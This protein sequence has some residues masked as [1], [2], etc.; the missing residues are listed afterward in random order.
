MLRMHAT[1]FMQ[2]KRFFPL[3]SLA[4]INF[5]KVTTKCKTA[6][7]WKCRQESIKKSR[8]WSHLVNK[9][10][11]DLIVCHRNVCVQQQQQEKLSR[12]ISWKA[13]LIWRKRV[14]NAVWASKNHKFIAARWYVSLFEGISASLVVG[15]THVRAIFT[16]KASVQLCVSWNSLSH[17]IVARQQQQ[18]QFDGSSVKDK[19][20]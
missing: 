9:L 2:V 13:Y 19:R 12:Q 11:V 5:T 7:G 20:Q 4:L 15:H 18:Q 17:S 8:V 6:H 14:E 16:I 3:R 10:Q 1:L